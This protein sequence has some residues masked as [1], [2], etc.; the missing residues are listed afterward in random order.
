MVLSCKLNAHLFLLSGIVFHCSFC[1]TSVILSL[2]LHLF[3]VFTNPASHPVYLLFIFFWYI[4]S[5]SLFIFHY[6]LTAF[7]TA[8]HCTLSLNTYFCIFYS[9]YLSENWL[10]TLWYFMF[11]Y[12]QWDIFSFVYRSFP[13]I[14]SVNKCQFFIDIYWSLCNL[15]I[16]IIYH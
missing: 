6:T 15:Q 13:W 5:C 2:C 14:I 7:F 16:C 4:H 8:V 3:F 12:P 1:V 11:Y 9:S 10:L